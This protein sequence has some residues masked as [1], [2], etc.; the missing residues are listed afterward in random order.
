MHRVHVATFAALAW[1]A[2]P[3]PLAAEPGRILDPLAA[4][5]PQAA[6]S[7]EARLPHLIDAVLR[8]APPKWRV[9]GGEAA[10]APLQPL[11]WAA[12]TDQ[13]DV[14]ETLLDHGAEVDARDVEGRTPLMMAA[15]FD[16]RAVADV[17]LARGADPLVRDA[18]DGNTPLDFSA[19]AGH[20]DFAKLLLTHGATIDG[21]ATRNGETPLHYASYYGRRKV[22]DLLVESGADIN[23]ADY[24][25]VRPLQ[26]ARRRLQGLAVELLLG[27]GARPD[28]LHDAVNAGDVARIQALIA[29][30]ADVNAYD[31]SGTPLHLAVS[32]G[33]TW[34]AAMLIDAGADLEAVGEP[35]NAHPLHLAAFGNH[36]EAARLLIDRGA[37]VDSRDSQMRTPLAVAAVYGNAEVAEE[38][39]V[40]AADPLAGDVYS[41]TP[42]HCAA[43]SGN[44]EMADLLLS[45]GVDVNIR[46]GHD[47]ESPLNYA[48]HNGNVAMV[49]FLLAR[50]AD[51]NMRDD[52]GRTPLQIVLDNSKSR[53]VVDLLLRLGAER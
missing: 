11:H 12:I 8:Y 5:L 37:A 14:V 16:S 20:A 47:G 24:S 22:I 53:G 23:A 7:P 26:Y 39:I 50:G 38:L 32:T 17:L 48:A 27:L 13:A 30:G 41:D 35:G 45:H 6:L 31:L 15:A 28:N 2:I 36:T 18:V 33:Q 42:L 19:M 9:Q 3:A 4:S 43:M 40:G 49:A 21:R 52:T 1:L 29:G 46:S 34:I 44:I 25:G 51:M 10:P